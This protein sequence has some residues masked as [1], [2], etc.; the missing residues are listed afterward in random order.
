MT[1]VGTLTAKALVRDKMS[2]ALCHGGI[3]RPARESYVIFELCT[4]LVPCL[5]LF[6]TE[7][8]FNYLIFFFQSACPFCAVP[9]DGT[10]GYVRLIFQDKLD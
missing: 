5:G 1:T 9:L 3:P 7:L 6:G 8:Y 2:S 4:F 10:P